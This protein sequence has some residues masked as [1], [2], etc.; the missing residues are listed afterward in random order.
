MSYYDEV[1]SKRLNRYGISF[2]E[3]LE[4]Q[5]KKA[6]EDYLL[7]STYRVDFDY[8]GCECPGILEP[9]KQDKTMTNSFL[10]TRRDLEIPNG[11]ILFITGNRWMVW[12]KEEIESSGYN[13]YSVLKMTHEVIGYFDGGEDKF[14]AYF[15]GTG[16]SKIQDSVKTG[17]VSLYAEDNNKILLITPSREDFQKD[18]YLEITTGNIKQSFVITGIDCQSTPQVAYLS[19]DPAFLREKQEN[20]QFDN[21][22]W[23]SGGSANGS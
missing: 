23:I 21:S 11:T 10:L 15:Q 18:L 12:W 17:S 3:R 16:S 13:R 9:N 6:F 19:I 1:Y 2:Q 22:Y 5:R 20:N 14:Y 8:E 4:N 7:K